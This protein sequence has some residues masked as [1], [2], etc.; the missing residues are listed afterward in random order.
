VTTSLPT[1]RTTPILVAGLI[2]VASGFDL[3]PCI[4]TA[5]EI[6]T[7][8]CGSSGYSDGYIGSRMELIERWLA[9]HFYTIFDNQLA[10]ARAGTV[11]VSYQHKVDYGYRNSMYGQQ[12]MLLDTKGNLAKQENTVNVQRKIVLGLVWIG[13]CNKIPPI[14]GYPPA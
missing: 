3:S 14:Y 2:D 10:T 4:A 12:A 5:N 6:V 7:E 1:P 8:V 13:S 9:A 11:A